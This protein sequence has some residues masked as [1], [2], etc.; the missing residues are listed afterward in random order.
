[1]PQTVPHYYLSLQFSA[2]QKTILRHDRLW[3]IAGTSQILSKL[4]EIELP[5]RAKENGGMV[6]V[7]GGGKFT[8]RFDSLENAKSAKVEIIKKI[9]STLPMLEFQVSEEP[10]KSESMQKAKDITPEP[11]YPGIINELNEQK[12][13]FRGY[14][15][16]YNSHLKVC[17]ECGEY[18]GVDDT[19][20]KDK[21]LWC[22][23]CVQSHTDAKIINPDKDETTIQKI[24]KA[25]LKEF[26]YLNPDIPL[27]LGDLFPDKTNSDKPGRIAVWFSDLNNMNKKVPLWLGQDEQVIKTTFDAVKKVNVEII[28]EALTKTFPNST[29]VKKNNK[30]Y[31]PFRIIVAG[32]DDLTIV[33]PDKCILEFTK[34]L[35]EKLSAK[36]KSLSE[37]HPDHPLNNSALYKLVAIEKV[38]DTTR[39]VKDPGP[40]CFGGSFVVTSVHTPFKKIHEVGEEL[41]KEA[42]TWSD[43][44]GNSVNWQILSTDHE[45][46]SDKPIKFEK[47]LMID[48]ESHKNTLSLQVYLKLCKEDFNGMSASSVQQIIGKI[49]EFENDAQK[50]ETW[51]KRKPAAGKKDSYIA[52]ILNEDSFRDES[53]KKLLTGRLATLFELLGIYPREERA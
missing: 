36:I 26:S 39:D 29:L 49:I 4:N 5:A 3:S 15:V 45:A 9:S 19:D 51:L 22:S 52:R 24:Y 25:Y 33:M 37:K 2:I 28:S 41:M 7:A 40:Y 30:T 53:T 48:D 1:M 20:L 44:K 43:R 12:R 14:G 32:G 50:L 31:I 17:D 46:D 8:A 27:D 35:S 10:V 16:T 42:K 47:P 38:K 21:K 23:Y 34:N 13:V 11:L 18:P 6:I